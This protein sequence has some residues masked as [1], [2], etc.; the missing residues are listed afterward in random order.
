MGA[1]LLRQNN[2]LNLISPQSLPTAIEKQLILAG[3]V[4]SKH[5]VPE[6]IELWETSLSKQPAEAVEWAFTE[7]LKV[8]QFFPKPAEILERV[9]EWHTQRRASEQQQAMDTA[10]WT[11]EQ[12]K[13]EGLPAGVEQFAGM[14]KRLVEVAQKWPEPL[15]PMR[16]VEL[17][18]RLAR[19]QAERE[20]S[21]A[22]AAK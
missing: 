10:R 2:S 4:F 15:P 18:E 20:A 12:L 7:H 17:K 3:Q 11:R 22:S 1:S 19:A 9:R 21:K 16:R 13:S 8:G 14:M 6:E 5:L